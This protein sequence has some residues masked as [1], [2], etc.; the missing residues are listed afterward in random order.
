ML[1]RVMLLTSIVVFVASLGGLVMRAIVKSSENRNRVNS[2][3]V[4]LLNLLD[5]PD[6]GFRRRGRL[7]L[8]VRSS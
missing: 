5:L 4:A 2:A 6:K 7:L 3:L 1:H 8:L